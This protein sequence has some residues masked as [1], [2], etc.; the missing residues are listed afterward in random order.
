MPANPGLNTGLLISTEHIFVSSQGHSIP[1]SLIQ[2]QHPSRFLLE[3]GISG[4]DPT[5]MLPGFNGVLVQPASD[6][7]AANLGNNPSADD[8]RGYLRAAES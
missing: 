2:I 3:L 6:R 8:F 7:R 5:A 1:Y 4:E